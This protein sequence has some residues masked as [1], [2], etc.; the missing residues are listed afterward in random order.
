MNDIYKTPR[1]LLAA[2]VQRDI[3][4]VRDACAR[5]A[6]D[7]TPIVGNDL[8]SLSDE[9]FMAFAQAVKAL[10]K[11]VST[12]ELAGIILPVMLCPPEE[13]KP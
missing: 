6:L 3:E 9:S 4:R 12:L 13:A 7:L 11:E 1:D 2:E 10:S 5:T 8:T